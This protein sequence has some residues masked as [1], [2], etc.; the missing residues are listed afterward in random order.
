MKTKVPHDPLPPFPALSALADICI[1]AQA[2]TPFLHEDNA[3]ILPERIHKGFSFRH[4]RLRGCPPQT[5]HKVRLK[6]VHLCKE[7]S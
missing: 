7:H 1:F 4:V 5:Q 6:I 3:Q 2:K